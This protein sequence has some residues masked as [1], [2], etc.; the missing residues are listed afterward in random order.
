[1]PEIFAIKVRSCVKSTK[2]LQV[3]GPK[4]FKGRI[5]E[6]LDLDYKVHADTDHVAKFHGDHSRELGD[7]MVK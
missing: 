4:F 3:F 7:R 1:M 6:F 2:I 5:P